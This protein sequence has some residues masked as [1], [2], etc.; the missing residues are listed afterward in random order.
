MDRLEAG[1]AVEIARQ[2]SGVSWPDLADLLCRSLVW[3]T[4]ALLGQQPLTLEQAQLVGDKLGLDAEVVDA[5]TLPPVRG[6]RAVDTSE[7]VVYRLQEMVQVYG[8]ALQRLIAE[9]FGDGI[10]SAID[11]ELEFERKQDPKGDRVVLTLNGK[12]LPYRVW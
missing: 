12:F 6:A 3:T 2:K 5:L 1:A 9:E 11:F 10:M 4:S 8:P 7:P